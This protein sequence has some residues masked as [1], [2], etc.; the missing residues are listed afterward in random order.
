MEGYRA[1][2]RTDDGKD[3]SADQNSSSCD[4]RVFEASEP[5]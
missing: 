5:S 1:K 4:H 2:S 3:Q